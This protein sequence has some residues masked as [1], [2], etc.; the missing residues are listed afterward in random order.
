M[1]S[2][3]FKKTQKRKINIQSNVAMAHPTVAD[4]RNIVIKIKPASNPRFIATAAIMASNLGTFLPFFSVSTSS[5]EERTVSSFVNSTAS[6]TSI[7]SSFTW[8]VYLCRPYRISC[9]FKEV[10]V[11]S[12]PV[13]SI[14]FNALSPFSEFLSNIISLI[15]LATGKSDVLEPFPETVDRR[16]ESWI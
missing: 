11:I 13:I 2:L 14:F 4:L 5:F 8:L 7:L 1:S 16:F 12:S 3:L 10:V 6:S 15:R 9:R